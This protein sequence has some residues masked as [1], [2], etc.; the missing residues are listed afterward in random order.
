MSV[1]V[2][3]LLNR[4]QFETDHAPDSSPEWQRRAIY[5]LDKAQKRLIRDAPFMSREVE[6]R[7]VLDPDIYGLS[8]GDV[9]ETTSDPWVLKVALTYPAPLPSSPARADWDLEVPERHAGK[10]LRVST[11]SDQPS[12]GYTRTREFVIREV[13]KDDTGLP[14]PFYHIF[15]SLDRPYTEA[16]ATDLQFRAFTR[17]LHLPA[18]IGQIRH[19]KLHD[20]PD[21]Q[22][23]AY[24]SGQYDEDNYAR[25]SL[26]NRVEGQPSV[27]TR[28]QTSFLPAPHVAPTVS[29]NDSAAW[30]G[31]EPPGSFLYALRLVMGKQ[32]MWLH[33]G[34][35]STQTLT[36]PSTSRTRPWLQSALG[37]ASSRASNAG[38]ANVVELTFPNFDFA[39]GF[40]GVGSLREHRSGFRV[41]IWRRRLTSDTVLDFD[42]RFYLLDE[43]PAD[44]GTY[45]D[46]GEFTPDR[47]SPA[48]GY[49]SV[50]PSLKFYPAGDQRYEL[51]IRAVKELTALKSETQIPNVDVMAVDLLVHLAKAYLYEAQGNT[52]YSRQAF[53]DYQMALEGVMRRTASAI[54]RSRLISLRPGGSSDRNRRFQ[55]RNDRPSKIEP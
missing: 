33:S 36:S 54:P 42:S 2:S 44:M 7:A 6:V 19:I 16:P 47:N 22:L 15:I 8:E 3:E 24:T 53:V 52:S 1:P 35:P 21:S 10:I 14:S 48:P 9:L 25:Y 23:E 37:P 38:S 11:P 50:Q 43:V 4:L 5:M 51:I 12:V 49:G 41:Q 45:I 18:G 34:N 17:D 13:W 32:E 31:P 29:V 27:F 55:Y 30:L 46:N 28:G 40:D 26:D 20:H 39:E